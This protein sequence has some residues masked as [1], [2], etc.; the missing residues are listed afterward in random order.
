MGEPLLSHSGMQ[1]FFAN[2]SILCLYSLVILKTVLLSAFYHFIVWIIITQPV[3]F[4]YNFMHHMLKKTIVT[5]TI[6]RRET[7][8]RRTGF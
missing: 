2:Q 1:Y 5:T 8:L 7:M 4:L 3:Y 6:T